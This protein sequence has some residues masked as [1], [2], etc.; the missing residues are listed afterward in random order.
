MAGRAFQRLAAT[1]VAD[2]NVATDAAYGAGGGDG[3]GVPVRVILRQPDRVGAFGDTR[4]L[5]SSIL[6]EVQIADA[7]D[8]ALGDW[9]KIDGTTWVVRADPQRDTERLFWTAEV[10]EQ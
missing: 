8:L 6:I 5:S 3:D 7:P 9:F 2:P 1:L 4:F 10:K